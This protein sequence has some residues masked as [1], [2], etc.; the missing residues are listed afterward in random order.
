VISADDIK[1]NLE[2][3]GDTLHYLGCDAFGI[4]D[5]FGP[6][7]FKLTSD[8][9]DDIA[10]P[11]ARI[12]SRHAAAARLAKASDEVLVTFVIGKAVVRN[13]VEARAATALMDA[14]IAQ[15]QPEVEDHG[16]TGKGAEV[17]IVGG[18]GTSAGAPVGTGEG[19]QTAA[20]R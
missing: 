6:D 11:L 10:P 7:L 15:R 14:Q 1:K 12:A 17:P 3:V 13:V 20:G 4:P 19:P 9:L 2:L 8:E 18:N 5:Q 16:V